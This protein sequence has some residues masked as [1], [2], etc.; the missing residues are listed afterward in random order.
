MNTTGDAWSQPGYDAAGNMTTIPQPANMA[1]QFIAT[2]D[3]WNC[4]VRLFDPANGY[5]VQ[6]NAYDGLNRRTIQKVYDY[7]PLIEER[8]YYYSDSWQILE[9][10]LGSTPTSADPDRQFVWGMRYIDKPIRWGT[11]KDGND[12]SS[13]PCAILRIVI[14]YEVRGLVRRYGA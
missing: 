3:A 9:E 8:H 12:G 11:T 7:G 10:R 4:L 14:T 2:Y 6:E 5:V 13:L 1:G